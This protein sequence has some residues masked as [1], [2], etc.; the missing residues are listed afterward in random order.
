M[1]YCFTC[2]LSNSLET[3]LTLV[4]LYYWP[5]MRASSSEV[6]SV[7]RKWG[8]VVA[9]LACAIRPTSAITRSYVGLLELFVTRDRLKFIF[10][11]M[12]SIG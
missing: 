12:A 1:F 5:C 9:A 4:D 6:P 8:L 7:S 10:L 2:T 3:V 11:E